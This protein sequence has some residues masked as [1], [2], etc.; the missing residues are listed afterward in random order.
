MNYLSWWIANL[1]VVPLFL[2]AALRLVPLDLTFAFL[3]LLVT[4]V[5]ETILPLL[6][7]STNSLKKINNL[8][9]LPLIRKKVKIL[10]I[11]PSLF[12]SFNAQGAELPKQELLLTPGEHRQFA[13]KQVRQFAITN[14]DVLSAKYSNKNGLLIKAK[15]QGH[16]EVIIWD[17]NGRK[18]TYSITILG[19]KRQQKWQSTLE[20]LK[21]M[22]LHSTHQEHQVEITGELNSLLPF[23]YVVEQTK[24]FPEF[25][26][27]V[28]LGPELKNKILEDVY[29]QFYDQFIDSISCKIEFLNIICQVEEGHPS[30]EGLKQSLEKKYGLQL[31]TYP[32]IPKFQNIKVKM[33]LIQMERSDGDAINFGLN[34]LNAKLKDILDRGLTPLIEENQVLLEKYQIKMES[35]AEPELILQLDQETK[36]TLGKELP[37]F[38]QSV[39][40]ERVVT[41]WKFTGLSISLKCQNINGK[42]V[43]SY[44][45]K[46]SSTPQQDG[47][48]SG[49]G[50]QSRVS[51]E[52]DSPI[53]LFDLSLK[54][55]EEEESGI[56]LLGDIPFVG[57]I[58]RSTKT[59]ALHKKIIAIME[60]S[61]HD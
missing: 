30:I 49:N 8:S 24:T 37:Y 39:S 20:Q 6:Y 10:I 19:A 12:L 32:S 48:I 23:Q 17:T 45:T 13:A 34:R 38:A 36:I 5:L 35:L 1:G 3:L 56:P 59:H 47:P 60:V 15:S 16:S 42:L 61:T 31:Y 40:G 51:L 52:L 43:M 26:W 41:D 57:R 11:L 29:H 14:R 25:S 22:G 33:K 21:Q 28:I 4:A 53:Q 27:K 58:F 54:G 50:Q 2:F 44:S 18:Q 55:S 46:L 7:R 9:Y